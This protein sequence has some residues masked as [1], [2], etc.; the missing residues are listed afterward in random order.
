MRETV[1]IGGGAAGMAA[2]VSSA[3]E[4][5]HVILLEHTGQLGRKLLS[6]GNGRCNLTNRRQEPSC[7]HCA[8]PEFPGRVLAGFGF[9][10]TYEFFAGLGLSFRERDGY[11]YPRSMKA[12][13]VR[14]ALLSELASLSVDIRTDT[15]PVKIQRSKD[16]LLVKTA[17][18]SFRA[19][20]VILACGGKA[21]PVSGSDGSG[22]GLAVSLGHRLKTPVPALTFLKG[23]SPQLKKAA[24]VRAEGRITLR[25]AGQVHCCMGELQ[26]TESGISGI[27]TFQV[28]RYASRALA[29]GNPVQAELSFLPEYGADDLPGILE[30]R[31]RS[32]PGRD[33]MELLTGWFPDKLAAALLKKAGIPLH[34]PAA[35]LAARQLKSLAA[36]IGRFPLEIT[37]TG[38]FSQAQVTAGGIDVSDVDPETLESRLVPGLYF[39]GEILDVDGDC[40][41]YNLQ[42]AWASGFLAGKQ[43]RS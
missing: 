5:D 28:S 22:Y 21:F 4:G 7:Y 16:A 23:T 30:E 13:S 40:G 2:A 6:T 27:P 19:D 29:E 33:A 42:W 24:G 10:E 12:S 34:I 26:I 17:D 25:A 43:G 37:G 31:V 32:L 18:S 36:A 3:R 1:V 14:E 8:D 38:D 39:A 15:V 35:S 20:A 11:L 41:G 9:R